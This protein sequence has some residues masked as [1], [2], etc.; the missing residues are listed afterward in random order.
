MSKMS[1]FVKGSVIAAALALAFS[2][3]GLTSAFAKARVEKAP[4]T[5][6]TSSQVSA[7]VI[8][9]TWKDE[10]AWLKF[11]NAV[12]GRIDRALEGVVSRFDR[13]DFSKRPDDRFAGRLRTMLSD[14][15]SLLSKAQAVATA[16]AGFDASGKMSDQNQAIKSIRELGT[17]LNELRGTLGSGLMHLL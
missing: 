7:L 8:Q 13:V 5:T 10:L 4:A 9:N 17:Y 2:S 11:D 1:V 14:V 12:L 16:H 15:Q 3:V 6:A